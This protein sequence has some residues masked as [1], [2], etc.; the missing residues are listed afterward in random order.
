MPR[1]PTPSKG[2]ILVNVNT[3][4]DRDPQNNFLT[5][6]LTWNEN[7]IL[8]GARHVVLGGHFAYVSADAGLVIVDLDDPLQPKLAAVVPL[9][10]ARAAALQFRYLFALDD[11]GLTTIDV[12]D[13][14]KA[15]PGRRARVPLADAHRIYVAR[16]YAYVAAGAEGL[17]IVDVE[18]PEKPKLL[19]EVHRGR[20][21]QRRARRRRRLDQCV[22]VRLCRRRRERT[23]GAPAHF[24]GQPAQVLRL[25]ARTQAEADRVARHREPG[26]RAC[27]RA[28]IATAPSTRPAARSP[29]SAASARGRSRGTR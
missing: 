27:P 26:A 24:A 25:L 1:S 2:L 3:L 11:E 19:H 21:A 12:T 14:A 28:S 17:A 9:K 15:A 23:E 5:R 4:A 10:G 22:A 29:C 16:T 7:G 6:A 8:N 13:P 18:R 20:Q